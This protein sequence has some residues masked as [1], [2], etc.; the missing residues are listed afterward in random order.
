MP[1]MVA[2]GIVMK[3]NHKTDKI[4]SVVI[5]FWDININGLFG[6]F[7]FY[8]IDIITQMQQE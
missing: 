2:M 7:S 4:P 1:V 3:R 6:L 5:V 8:D